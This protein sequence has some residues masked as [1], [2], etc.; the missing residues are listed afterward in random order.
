MTHPVYL[1]NIILSIIL[2]YN[3]LT[4]TY[5]QYVDNMAF[6]EL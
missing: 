3:N 1:R 2:L 5:Y 6:S 4:Q